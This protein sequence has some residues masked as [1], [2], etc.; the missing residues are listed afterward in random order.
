MTTIPSIDMNTAVSAE[1]SQTSLTPMTPLASLASLDTVTGG[2]TPQTTPTPGAETS[3]QRAMAEP[4]AENAALGEAFAAAVAAT[5]ASP[6]S[7]GPTSLTTPTSPTTPEPPTSP[8]TPEPAAPAALGRGGAPTPPAATMSSDVSDDRV[9]SDVRPETLAT[10]GDVRSSQSSLASQTSLGPT[11]LTPPTSPTTQEPAAPAALGRGGAPTPPA[12]AKSGDV[13]DVRVDSDVRP[14]TVA[15]TGDVS[16]DGGETPAV[17][18]A[19]PNPTSLTPP[20]SLATPT[21]ADSS[22]VTAADVVRAQVAATV[23]NGAA[24]TEASAPAEVLVQAANAVADTLLVSPGL[25]RGQ[26]EIV[27]QLRPDVLDGTEVRIA[28]TGRQLDVQFCPTTVD[29]SVMLENGRAQIASCLSAKI[30][31]FNVTVD[32]RKKRA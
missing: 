21:S 10:T 7:P 12:A 30:A 1:P 15:T 3:F 9:V 16:D 11:S 25:L 29:M 6:E 20:T 2:M 22:S 23:V 8:T 19:A 18:A 26:G 4:I 31:A 24:P 28:V 27:V 32:V 13:S 17:L 14:G 5:V